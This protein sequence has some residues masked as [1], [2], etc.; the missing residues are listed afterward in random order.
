MTVFRTVAGLLG[1]AIALHF[2]VVGDWANPGR[3]MASGGTPVDPEENV[4][5]C[6]GRWQDEKCVAKAGKTCSSA[7]YTRY[8]S[9][10][11]GVQNTRTKDPSTQACA[12]DGD[13]CEKQDYFPARLGCK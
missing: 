13:N 8:L 7:D 12:D 5:T 3:V 2:A 9:P 4:A 1:L 11:G 10:G 6:T